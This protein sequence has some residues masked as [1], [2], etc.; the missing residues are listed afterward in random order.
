M[1]IGQLVTPTIRLVRELGRGGMGTVWAAED[2]DLER[3]VAVKLLDPDYASED[4]AVMRFRQE[5]QRAGKVRAPHVKT[6]FS[7]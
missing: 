5:A 3:L 6:V 1:T 2:L 7:A 4:R